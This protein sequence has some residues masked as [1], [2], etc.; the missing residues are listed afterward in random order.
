MDGAKR[1]PAPAHDIPI[2]LG[3]M[4]PRM[5]RLIG[6][7]ADGWLPT[8]LYLQPGDLA[9]GNEIIDAAAAGAG[10]DPRE[11][12]RL[13]NIGGSFLPERRD[14][15]QGPPSSWV[16]DLLPLVVE[17]G[18]STFILASDDPSTI[19]NFALD[20]IPLLRDAVEEARAG[21]GT[22]TGRVRPAAALARR[23]SGIDY[24][25]VPASLA[26]AA[27]EPGDVRYATVRNT[28]LRGGSPGLVLPVR[29]AEQAA[30]ALGFARAQAG[31]LSLRSGGHGI[32]GRS[33][34]DGGIVI[35]VSALNAIEVLDEA[36]RRVRVGAGARW[37]DVAA[38][39]EP[40]GW[41]LTSGD[42]GG[43]GVGVSP[44]REGSAGSH[45]STGSR[46][47]ACGAWSS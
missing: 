32:S 34:N 19:Q 21:A 9:R 29:D 44:P 33:T 26:E 42:Y 41:A 24:D 23:R 38:A 17:D 39:L 47:T 10:R 6:R 22:S 12:R 40:H 45:E 28:Y 25:A 2:W 43:V 20:V 7:K 37:M 3:A 27:I 36:T 4:K 8:Y 18:V 30:E 15:L 5:Q 16:H 14:T 35:D 1:G 13:L 11:V 31:P 46:S